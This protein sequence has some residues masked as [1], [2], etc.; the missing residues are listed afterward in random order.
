MPAQPTGYVTDNASVLSATTKS[1]LES[2]CAQLEQ[3]AHAQVFTAILKT[4]DNDEPIDQFANELFAK[5]KVGTKGTNRGVL[6]VVSMDHKYRFE[7]G[8]GLEGILNDAKVGDIGREMVPLLKQAQ[9]DQAIQT[10][11]HGVGSVIAADAN[12]TITSPVHQYHRQPVRTQDPGPLPAGIRIFGI[13]F[14]ILILFLVFR[15]RGGGG[16]GPGGG[17]GIGGFL[18]GMILGNLLGG[19]GRGG[20]GGG[21][22]GDNE[23]G[24]FGGGGG[25]ES[26]GGGASGNW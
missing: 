17:S 4:I 9:Y 3:K 8:F 26:G 15:R 21:D 20:F 22:G 23:G 6:I 7:V 11:V 1:D 18:T 13:L 16:G 5:W 19:G 24:G 2:Y 25:G 14:V 10:A 12:V